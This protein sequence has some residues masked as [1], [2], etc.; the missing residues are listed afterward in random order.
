MKKVIFLLLFAISAWQ[1]A[2]AQNFIV[3]GLYYEATSPT[4]VAV[5]KPNRR[6]SGNISIPM[7][8]T[9]NNAVYSVTSIGLDAFSLNTSLTSVTIPN[10]VKSIDEYAFYGCSGLRSL[11]CNVA[12]PLS[13]T[14]NVFQY[15][16]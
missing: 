3:D 8:V 11:I 4:T 2:L 6:V 16:N 12:N 9:Y 7:L 1:H 10:S 15:V 5:A 13:I 14:T